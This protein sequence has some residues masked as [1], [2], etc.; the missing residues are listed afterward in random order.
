M[1]LREVISFR[2]GK[3]VFN[4]TYV[5]PFGDNYIQQQQIVGTNQTELTTWIVI[6]IL[7]L[8]EHSLLVFATP[9]GSLTTDMLVIDRDY[10][11]IESY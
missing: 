1:I 4:R 6:W 7:S 9:Q 2:V 3:N 11:I 8:I 5:V 10:E